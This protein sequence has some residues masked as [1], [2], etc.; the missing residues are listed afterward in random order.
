MHGTKSVRSGSP[1]SPFRG[2]LLSIHVAT[3]YIHAL[4]SA[5]PRHGVLHRRTDMTKRYRQFIT[6]AY[7]ICTVWHTIPLSMPRTYSAHF[8]T[9]CASLRRR[10]TLLTVCNL[11]ES[12]N[13][14]ASF[15]TAGFQ[16]RFS[17]GPEK[18]LEKIQSHLK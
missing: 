1:G 5:A 2:C 11:L 12:L 16:K 14:R 18:I 15:K 4:V 9:K 3:L 13:S 7:D 17:L 6:H 8:P 10:V